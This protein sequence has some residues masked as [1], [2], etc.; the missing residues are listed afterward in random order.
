M[1]LMISL[2]Q[3]RGGISGIWME[4]DAWPASPNSART[5]AKIVTI[6]HR[7]DPGGQ[8]GRIV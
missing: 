7:F 5:R 8:R 1:E 3:R 2:V 6:W 4:P